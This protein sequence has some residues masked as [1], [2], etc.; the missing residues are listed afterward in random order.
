MMGGTKARAMMGTSPMP[1]SIG[2]SAVRVIGLPKAV[3]E[4][5]VSTGPS[6]ATS[7]QAN[8]MVRVTGR[9]CSDKSGGEGSVEAGNAGLGNGYEGCFR[10]A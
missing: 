8:Q 3:A 10:F 1:I 2:C 4:I 9:T 5:E 7:T 6:A